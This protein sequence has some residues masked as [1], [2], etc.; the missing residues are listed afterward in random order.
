MVG[1]QREIGKGAEKGD[2]VNE[3]R[4]TF[5]TAAL[6]AVVPFSS[7]VRVGDWVYVSGQIGNVPGEMRLVAGGLEAEARQ[8]LDRLRD[9]LTRG[10]LVAGSGGEVHGLFRRHERFPEIQR[11]YRGYFQSPPGAERVE[12]QGLAL[13]A[14]LEI[15]CVALAN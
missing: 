8:A 5:R 2:D 1:A 10:R 13:G 7:A 14:R 11:I 4:E 3:T 15:D 12:V 9:A 6:P